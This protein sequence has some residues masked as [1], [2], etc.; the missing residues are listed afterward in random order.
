MKLSVAGSIATVALVSAGLAAASLVA[1]GQPGTEM[2][3]NAG[4]AATASPEPTDTVDSVSEW[5][6]QVGPEFVQN[7]YDMSLLLTWLQEQP[8]IEESGYVTTVGDPETRAVQFHWFG[9][10]PLQQQ[11]LDRAAEAG[12]SAT[13]VARP[14]SVPELGAAANRIWE[15]SEVARLGFTISSIATISEDVDAFVVTGEFSEGDGDRQDL[16]E[17]TDV[18]S[19]IAG[20]PVQVEIGRVLPVMG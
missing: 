10:S 6:E 17:I 2:I 18:M 1:L 13:I 4:P 7:Q 11:A 9:E 20:F 16:A 3:T 12:I 8:G 19:R 5:V 14:H 15:S